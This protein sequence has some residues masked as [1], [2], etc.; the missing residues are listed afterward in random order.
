MSGT[1]LET[2]KEPKDTEYQEQLE[3]GGMEDGESFNPEF[4][5]LKNVAFQDPKGV[6]A[7]YKQMYQ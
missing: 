6:E 3:W 4:F 5:E 7:F 2:L 1:L